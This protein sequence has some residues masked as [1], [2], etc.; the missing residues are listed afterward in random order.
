M[1]EVINYFKEKSL[2]K[3]WNPKYDELFSILTVDNVDKSIVPF[4]ELL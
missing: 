3:N 1:W 4:I 2:K